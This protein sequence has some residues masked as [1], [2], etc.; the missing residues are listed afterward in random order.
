MQWLTRIAAALPLMMLCGSMAGATPAAAA[1]GNWMR[2]RVQQ[3]EQKMLARVLG[4][5][6]AARLSMQP[7]IIGGTQAAPGAWPFQAGLLFA[8]E[9][10]NFQ[11]QFCGASIIDGLFILTAAHCVDF[12]AGPSDI[13][14]LTNTQ[15]LASGG[16]R[17]AVAKFKFHPK[18]NPQTSD[19]DVAVIKL[20]KKVTGIA[21]AK[22]AQMITKPATEAALAPPK[23]KAT[24]TGW[25]DIDPSS[26]KNFP[27]ELRQVQVP[28]VS[29]AVCN[30]PASYDGIITG[31]MICAGF[32]AG[33]KDSCQGDSG[34]PLVVRNADGKFRAQVGIVS[35]GTGCA[36]PNLYGVYSRLAVLGPWV[37]DTMD[38]LSK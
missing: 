12:L 38:K 30:A 23:T 16:V 28:I 20:K 7:R 37:E 29:N 35:F 19:F 26:A 18:W 6:A 27:T 2:D 13:H 21:A 5:Q 9:A 1:E 15:S 36:L 8:D 11:A 10:D 24:V 3:W 32:K 22:F 31:R 17:H 34:G 25:G 14:V 33:G 4:Q